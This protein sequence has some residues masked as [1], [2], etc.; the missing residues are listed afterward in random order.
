M[1]KSQ[2]TTQ[3]FKTPEKTQTKTNTNGNLGKNSI[4]EPIRASSQG[5][6]MRSS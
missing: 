2:L 5:N 1:V 6:S 3:A 4:I